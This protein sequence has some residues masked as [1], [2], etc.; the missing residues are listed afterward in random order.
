ML[1]ADKG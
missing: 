1:A